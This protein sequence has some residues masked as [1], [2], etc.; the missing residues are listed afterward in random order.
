MDSTHKQEKRPFLGPNTSVHSEGFF[1]APYDSVTI[2]NKFFLCD[3]ESVVLCDNQSVLCDYESV[4][5]DTESVVLCDNQSVVS[6]D[7]KSVV[8]S[9]NS[10]SVVNDTV[11]C[12]NDY[13]VAESDFVCSGLFKNFY[14]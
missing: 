3:N 12:A 4:L 11:D 5:C 8:F 9:S 2:A 10:D 13:S 6:S 7:N 1:D 14:E